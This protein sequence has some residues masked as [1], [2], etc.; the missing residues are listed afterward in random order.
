VTG[1]NRTLTS[2]TVGIVTG[3]G[4]IVFFGFG[5]FGGEFVAPPGPYGADITAQ[6]YREHVD[7]KR[8]A[9]ICLVIGGTFMIAFGSAIADRLRKV[10]VVGVTMAFVQVGTAVAAGTLMMAFAAFLL[11]ALLFPDMPNE[12]LRF[13]NHVTWMAWAGLWQPGALQAVAVATAIL[14][15]KSKSPV[16]PRWIAWY[17]LFMA[18]GSLMGVLI[19]FFRN[20]PFAWDGA[21]AFYLAGFNY[22]LWFAIMLTQF[23]RIRRRET[24]ESDG[25]GVSAHESDE[26]ISLRRAGLR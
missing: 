3:W 23:H 8:I 18:F 7:L 9:V 11:T 5:L 17:S 2:T 21:V 20:G 25:W 16:Y 10:E 12:F 14:S 1:S 24:Q 26:L 22:F 13:S 6:F 4:V 19:P 15:D